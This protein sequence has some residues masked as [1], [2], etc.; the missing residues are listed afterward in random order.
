MSQQTFAPVSD[1]EL[2][3]LRPPSAPGGIELLPPPDSAPMRTEKLR[4]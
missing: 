4:P 1:A 2:L 3:Q